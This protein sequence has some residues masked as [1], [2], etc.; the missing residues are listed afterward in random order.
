MGVIHAASAIHPN[1]GCGLLTINPRTILP[2]A[3]P[4]SRC[5]I[6]CLD[7]P[8]VASVDVRRSSF[9]RTA[10]NALICRYATEAAVIAKLECCACHSLFYAGMTHA[11]DC[12]LLHFLCCVQ[13][14]TAVKMNRRHL[15]HHLSDVLTKS[16]SSS[17]HTASVVRRMVLRTHRWH[18]IGLIMCAHN[19]ILA[20]VSPARTPTLSTLL[21]L[22]RALHLCIQFGRLKLLV[23]RCTDL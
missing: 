14:G 3:R 19:C 16:S 22:R 1:H 6:W 7:S 4:M 11:G 10:C 20:H 18:S 5:D 9:T 8:V 12:A 13:Q 2:K 21:C 23:K 15:V 17:K